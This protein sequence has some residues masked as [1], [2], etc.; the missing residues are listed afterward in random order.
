MRLS[1]IAAQGNPSGLGLGSASYLLVNV[2][3][4][5]VVHHPGKPAF[6]EFSLFAAPG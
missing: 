4:D 2:S 5:P 6:L 3:W 1:D